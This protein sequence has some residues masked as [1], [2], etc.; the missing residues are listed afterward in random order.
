MFIV[1]RER[2]STEVI[3]YALYLYFLGL[4]FRNTSKAIRRFEE[5]GRSHVAM[6]KWV[7]RFTHRRLYCCK[8]VSAFLIDE[9][10]LQIRSS[11]GWLFGLISMRVF[12]TVQFAS[13]QQSGYNLT[14]KVPHHS[15]GDPGVNIVVTTENGYTD[16]VQVSTAGQPSWT[17]SIP[18]DLG[19]SVRVCVYTHLF[20]N[21]ENCRIWL[22][23]VLTS[24]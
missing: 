17:F 2:T 12:F 11:E 24:R 7:Q 8:R 16:H 3:M 1:E 15:F 21:G 5:E 18:A 10:T 23:M 6:W 19:G 9:T 13:A 4:S 14:V 22:L 20:L